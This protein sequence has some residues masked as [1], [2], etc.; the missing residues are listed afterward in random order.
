MRIAFNTMQVFNVLKTFYQATS[1]EVAENNLPKLEAGCYSKFLILAR[2]WLNNWERL[3]TCFDF[4]K[5]IRKA[6]YTNNPIE[7][8]HGA[9]PRRQI[10]KHTKNKGVFPSDQAVLKLVYLLSQN[11]MAK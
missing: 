1:L 9:A 5:V 11:I 10:R 6:I 2:T 4:T 3:A 8:Y 7:S